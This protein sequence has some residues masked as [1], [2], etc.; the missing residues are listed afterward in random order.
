MIVHLDGEALICSKEDG[1][2]CIYDLKSGVQLQIL[3]RHISLVHILT[4]WPHREI[5]MSVDL[6]NR[7]SWRGSSR[8]HL[9]ATGRSRLYFSLASIVEKLSLRYC[10][11][12]RPGNPYCQHGRRTI[13]GLYPIG[14]SLFAIET[15]PLLE[16]DLA[17]DDDHVQYPA[18]MLS[19]L[20]KETKIGKIPV[21]ILSKKLKT[22]GHSVSCHR[23]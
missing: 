5:L 7:E 11:A 6:S 17:R 22:L 21:P 12:T 8:S 18:D 1:S 9:A 16:T 10:R 4:W 20:I 15:K 14:S 23:A 2:V 13:F 19:Q 3:Y